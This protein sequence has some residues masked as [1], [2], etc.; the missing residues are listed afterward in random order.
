MMDRFTVPPDKVPTLAQRSLL[1]VGDKSLL[2]FNIDHQFYAIE[3]RCPH[4]GAS[5]C[6]SQ[7]NGKNIQ[8][9]A[10]GLSFDVSSGYLRNSTQMKITCYPI[11]VIGE[12]L[13]ILMDM[14]QD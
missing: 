5:F 12:Q 13:F 10:H 3:D 11:E 8:C 9:T 7:L 4:Q 6:S 2:L 14:E 1:Y